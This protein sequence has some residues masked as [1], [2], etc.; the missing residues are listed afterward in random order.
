MELSM[1]ILLNPVSI[2]ATCIGITDVF[3]DYNRG[4]A[5]CAIANYYWHKKWEE[6]FGMFSMNQMDYTVIRVVQC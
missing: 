2:L 5:A 3:V 1:S 6:P 4:H